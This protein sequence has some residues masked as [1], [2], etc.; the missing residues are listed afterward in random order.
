M[1]SANRFLPDDFRGWLPLARRH[2]SFAPAFLSRRTISDRLC[3]LRLSP[4]NIGMTGQRE[5]CLALP[6]SDVHLRAML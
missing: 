6:Q 2:H 1:M 4:G 3:S 5:G